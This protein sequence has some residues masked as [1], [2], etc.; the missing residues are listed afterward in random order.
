M[1]EQKKR[2]APSANRWAALSKAVC[3]CKYIAAHLI[4]AIGAPILAFFIA[5]AL[6]EVSR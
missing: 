3:G 1:P 2:A 4:A 5:V 6:A